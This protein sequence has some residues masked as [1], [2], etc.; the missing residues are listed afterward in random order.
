[1][2]DYNPGADPDDPSWAPKGRWITWKHVHWD[3]P[4]I[5]ERAWATAWEAGI[6]ALAF[7]L[8]LLVSVTKLSDLDAVLIS[9]GVA[10]L[11]ALIGFGLTVA[12]IMRKQKLEAEKAKVK[13]T[14]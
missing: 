3:W 12:R 13:S 4:D 2:T 9:V 11:Q 5:L 8:P 7:S 14:F 10:M 1:M 6:P